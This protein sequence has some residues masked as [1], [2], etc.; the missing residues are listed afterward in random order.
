MKDDDLFAWFYIAVSQTQLKK[1]KE[2]IDI[3]EGKVLVID[4]KNIDAMTNLAY[5]YREIGN[6]KKAL[7]YLMKADQLQKEQQ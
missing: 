6:N 7:E 2:A 1:F 3:Y 5:C 4:P